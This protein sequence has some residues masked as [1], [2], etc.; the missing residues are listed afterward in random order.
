MQ[1]AADITDNRGQLDYLV[2]GGRTGW[3]NQLRRVVGR[4][5]RCVSCDVWPLIRYESNTRP[6]YDGSSSS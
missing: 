6:A 4:G 3:Q 1:A 2:P 5:R